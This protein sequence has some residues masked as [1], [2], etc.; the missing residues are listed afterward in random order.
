M[1]AFF[2]CA[3]LCC[4]SAQ[5][6]PWEFEPPIAVSG[7]A[8]QGVFVHLESA[9]RK[10]IAVSAEWVAVTWEDNRDGVPRCYVSLKTPGQ[11][12][13]GPALQVSVQQEAAEPAIVGLDGGNFALAWEENGRVWVRSL[14]AKSA[15]LGVPRTLSTRPGTQASL[16]YAARGD[17][18][19][20][21]SEQGARYWQIK[22]ARLSIT[23]IGTGR[24]DIHAA[25]A[26]TVDAS[27]LG[28]QSYPS[29]A[30]EPAGRAVVAWEDRRGGHTRLYSALSK[31]G[32][33][34]IAPSQPLNEAVWRGQALDF[35][36]G[37]G[38]M[39]VALA[40]QGRDG[41]AAV[42]ADKR[43]F[44]SG[45]DVYGGFARGPS[46]RFGANE[47]VQDE[48]GNNFA[49]WHPAVAANRAGRVAVVWDDDREGSPD[50]WL[51]WRNADG[52]SDDLAV[53]G[54]SG[55]GVQ[56]DPSVA[57]DAAGNLH[58]AWVEKKDLNSPSSIR[59]SFGRVQ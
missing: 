43:D 57:M 3:M 41:V 37:T 14:V 26:V 16:G 2:F 29:I 5:A 20:V 13:F 50:V 27:A 15:S 6:A 30:V 40:A 45:Y 48:F 56:S 25:R 36:R 10:S 47:K 28:D 9:G 12:S 52:W 39:R 1:R 42:W 32:G 33:A 22:L 51:S 38:V 44:Q 53:P 24:G 23:G 31:Y 11:N 7:D 8:A 49:Q 21:W 54:A 55:P 19:A 59:Y 34:R 18:Y 17:L 4:V 58:L 46:F 35:G